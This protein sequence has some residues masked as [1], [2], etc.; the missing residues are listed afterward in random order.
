[1]DDAPTDVGETLAENL[2]YETLV[3]GI[4]L[5]LLLAGNETAVRTELDI[6]KNLLVEKFFL[7]GNAD[8]ILALLGWHAVHLNVANLGL[9]G[10]GDVLL[11]HDIVFCLWNDLLMTYI[12]HRKLHL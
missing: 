4:A 5:A 7:C 2:A 1:M 11:F 8:N 3:D 12:C 10:Q 9:L 6:R